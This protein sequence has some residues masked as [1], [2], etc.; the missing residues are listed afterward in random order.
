M[1]EF[2]S[3]SLCNVVYKC[4]A[5][6]LANRLRKVLH[7]VIAD[8]QS[9]FIPSRCITNNAMVG[10]ECMHALRRK[11][12][13]KWSSYMSLKLDM[14][15]A[16]NRVEWSLVK[17]MMEAYGIFGASPPPVGYF[18]INTDAALSFS[19]KIP[20]VGVVIQ[21][22]GGLVMA[23]LCGNARGFYEPQIAE[24]KAILRGFRLALETGLYT[25]I[26]ESDALSVVNL[27]KAKEIPSSDV[28][29]V[30]H[31]ILDLF[32]NVGVFS[33]DFAPRL[34]NKVAHGLAKI[35]LRSRDEFV[36]MEDCPLVVESLVLGDTPRHM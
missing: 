7:C 22:S 35:A 4:I 19:D 31:D 20:G 12:F 28:S 29:V 14:S 11:V 30:I 17:G 34:A 18:K 6:T 24:A 36:W 26:L 23:C 33:C 3:N 8:T 2:C 13:G 5:K 1:T 16:Y 21:D 32:E 27:I 15:K 9:A 25:A 10:F